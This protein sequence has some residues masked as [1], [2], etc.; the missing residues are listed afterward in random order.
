MLTI[1]I[2]SIRCWDETNE[3]FVTSPEVTL[4]LE[5]SLIALSK[6][7]SKHKKRFLDNTIDKT[8]DETRDYIRCMAL[9]DI[10]EIAY[11]SL[12][13][14]RILMN[15]II[16]YIGDTHTATTIKPSNTNGNQGEAV[17]SE[18]IYYWM[19]VAQIPWEAQTW[20][21]NRL[22]TLISVYSEKNKPQKAM[23]PKIQAQ[24]NHELNR[25]RRAARKH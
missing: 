25:A 1:K 22:I 14:N 13:R 3:I 23:D 21:L 18:L 10:P 19:T 8:E 16:Q 12:F 7:E 4:N 5:H 17:T 6:W 11:Q 20:H 24:Q 2:P 9:N 15:S